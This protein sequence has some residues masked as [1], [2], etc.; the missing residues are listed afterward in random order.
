MRVIAAIRQGKLAHHEAVVAFAAALESACERSNWLKVEEFLLERDIRVRLGQV[1][2]DAVLPD[3]AVRLS[4]RRGRVFALAVEVDMATENTSYFAKSKGLGYAALKQS[5]TPILGCLDWT[6]ICIVPTRR[7]L[8]R[9]VQGLIDAEVE[10]GWYFAVSSEVRPDTVLTDVF[11]QVQVTEDGES[12]VLV[13]GSPFSHGRSHEPSC[14][15][16]R[17]ESENRCNSDMLE[18]RP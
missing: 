9:L 6:P 17:V 3:A 8:H 13:K 2:R 11:E 10:A 18:G 15:S 1:P 14:R 16:G 4:D 5:G 12:A 7:R